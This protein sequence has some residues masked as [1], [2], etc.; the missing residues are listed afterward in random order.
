MSIHKRLPE[1]IRA[2]GE[3]LQF[4]LQPRIWGS[5]SVLTVV[6]I[7]FWQFSE[8]PEWFS[9]D[10][11]STIN[12]NSSGTQLTPEEKSIAADIDSSKI[13]LDELNSNNSFIAPLNTTI[14]V[15]TDL[16]K[17]AQNAAK[18][19]EPASGS[20]PILESLLSGTRLETQPPVQ[21]KSSTSS[22]RLNSVSGNTPTPTNSNPNLGLNG[23]ESPSAET[24]NSPT[25]TTALQQAMQNSL[26]RQEAGNSDRAV[27]ATTA[28]QT[29][30]NSEIQGLTLSN[31]SPNTLTNPNS[32]TVGLT[33]FTGTS[34]IT[35][36]TTQPSWSV[37]RS[38]P[39]PAGGTVPLP[40]QN[41]YQTNVT[42]PPVV[43]TVPT[44]TPGTVSNPGYSNLNPPLINNTIP[45][46]SVTPN[47]GNY[48]T[49]QP[50]QPNTYMTPSN[51]NP[52]LQPSQIGQNQPNFSVPNRVP[53]RYIGG[54]E[55][56]TFANP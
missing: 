6:G 23:L 20:N 12:N 29:T 31:L 37:P 51:F 16:L 34:T 22:N 54:G 52:N 17:Q 41:P 3:E 4:L 24:A 18:N 28:T 44:V 49:V 25:A 7:F 56:N 42:L 14:T 40:V 45:S 19:S 5:I 35:G 30:T 55:I 13:L 50:L 33:P 26:Q 46:Y 8:H 9:L 43:P 53:G 48:G 11:E 21:E 36:Q 39:N 2:V 27:S 1:S 10:Q 47:T 15:E 38:N 32:G